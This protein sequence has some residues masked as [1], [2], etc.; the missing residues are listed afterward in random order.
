MILS[1]RA[2]REALRIKPCDNEAVGRER[3]EYTFGNIQ[4]PVGM[5]QLLTQRQI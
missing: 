4:K 1:T 2:L 5:P 3:E